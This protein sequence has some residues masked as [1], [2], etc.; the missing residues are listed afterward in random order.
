M[1]KRLF[2]RTLD[3]RFFLIFLDCLRNRL[4]ML[5]SPGWLEWEDPQFAEMA[6]RFRRSSL[7]FEELDDSSK[8]FL[9]LMF[10]A[11]AMAAWDT[12]E[13]YTHEEH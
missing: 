12:H 10:A 2:P 4:E 3:Q 9:A 1:E 11:A 6:E 8:E 13:D 5:R 7:G